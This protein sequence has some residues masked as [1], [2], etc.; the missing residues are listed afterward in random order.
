MP[1]DLAALWIG[2]ITVLRI[3]T[4]KLF[5]ERFPV[6][7]RYSRDSAAGSQVDGDVA[8]IRKNRISRVGGGRLRL[9]HRFKLAVGFGGDSFA[10]L[11]FGHRFPV[12]HRDLTR[13]SCGRGALMSLLAAALLGHTALIVHDGGLGRDRATLHHRLLALRTGPGDLRGDGGGLAVL[14]AGGLRSPGGKRRSAELAQGQRRDQQ[15]GQLLLELI[16]FLHLKV[17]L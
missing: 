10:G 14:A 15:Q 6:H 8:L 7:R 17:L 11:R 1:S 5:H 3:G 16:K 9:V 12:L 2:D 13:L 4:G